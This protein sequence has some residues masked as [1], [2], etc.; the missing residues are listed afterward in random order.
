[1]ILAK[2]RQRYPQGSLVSELVDMDR[3]TYIVGV[4]VIVDNIILATGLAGADRVETAE[5]MARERAIALLMLDDSDDREENIIASTAGLQTVS[6]AES[7]NKQNSDAS[8]TPKKV[9]ERKIN[10]AADEQK[11]GELEQDSFNQEAQNQRNSIEEIEDLDSLPQNNSTTASKTKIVSEEIVSAEKLEVPSQ[12]SSSSVNLFAGTSNPSISSE[13]ID[14]SQN[15]ATSEPINESEKSSS[16]DVLPEVNFNEIRH[17]TDIELKRLG[18][19]RD[20]GREFLQSRYGKRS[21]LQLTDSQLLEFL[22]YLASQP[23]PG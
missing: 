7:A 22:E 21:R 14:N 11:I 4:S 6:V 1:M 17:Q 2:F 13:L 19:T 3:G 18:W 23:T 16:V 9:A 5:D 8:P 20:D 15:N 10:A 12:T